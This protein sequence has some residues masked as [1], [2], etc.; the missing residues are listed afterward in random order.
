MSDRKM[1][2]RR[3]RAADGQAR[4]HIQHCPP[5]SR[6]SS[7]EAPPVSTTESISTQVLKQ[8]QS[9]RLTTVRGSASSSL[10][11]G[12]REPGTGCGPL[13]EVRA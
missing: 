12:V 11:T 8:V 9:G 6:S 3:P 13:L 4:G 10:N 5:G 7:L 1:P 2:N